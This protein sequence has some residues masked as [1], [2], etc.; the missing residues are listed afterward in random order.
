LADGLAHGIMN[1]IDFV[2]SMVKRGYELKV[3]TWIEHGSS[4]FPNQDRKW[5]T[6]WIKETN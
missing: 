3:E 4:P 5:K 1:E 2:V 6:N